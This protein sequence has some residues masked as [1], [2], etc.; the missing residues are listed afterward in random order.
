[1]DAIKEEN[2]TESKSRDKILTNQRKGYDACLKKIDGLIDMRANQ[3]IGEDDFSR[4]KDELTRE[5]DRLQRLLKD[6]DKNVDDWLE[7]ARAMFEFAEKAKTK[8]EIGTLKDK[9]LILSTIG[10]NLLLQD[11]TL[12]IEANKVIDHIKEMAPEVNKIYKRL[13]PLKNGLNKR[14]TGDLYSCNPTILP[15]SGSN[16]QPTGYT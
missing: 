6:T 1:M 16:R 10:S 14:K 12:T 3:E 5:K 9:R 11:G 7:R 13:E 15:G 8:F 4:R 2:K